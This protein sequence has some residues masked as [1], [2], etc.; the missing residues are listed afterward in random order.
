[1]N[2]YFHNYMTKDE[3]SFPTVTKESMMV[4]CIIDAMEGRD[5]ATADIYGAFPQMDMV[6]GNFTV[7][8][9]LCGVL[10]DLLVKID[11]LKFTDK[12]VLKGG[13]KVIYAVLKKALYGALIASL[14]FWK[15]LS[16]TL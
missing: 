12:V 15:Y 1:M 6:H 7:C 3:T 8:A 5:V 14:L 9:R 11:Q 4:T 10:A 13:Q 2:K 16:C